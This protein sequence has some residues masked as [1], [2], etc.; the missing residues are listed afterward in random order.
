M[1]T[2][3]FYRQ[4]CVPCQE[5]TFF[6]RKSFDQAE[7][8]CK[9]CGSE[10][11]YYNLKDIPENKIME[12]RERWKQQRSEQFASVFGGMMYGSVLLNA[13]LGGSGGG[14]IHEVENDAGQKEIDAGQKEI[15]EARAKA[16]QEAARLKAEKEVKFRHVGRN[17]P[18]LCGSGL[19]Y[20]K[21]CL[22]V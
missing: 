18:C 19:K 1:P 22:N 6:R 3:T 15:D 5:W 21:C 12:Q 11:R 2:Q 14:P 10:E 7:L 4:W 9:E 8:C 16:R 13:G 17:D 20:K